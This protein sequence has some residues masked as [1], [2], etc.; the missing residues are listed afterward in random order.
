MFFQSKEKTPTEG[1]CL[2]ESIKKG[3][4]LCDWVR[5]GRWRIAW[6]GEE[7][8]KTQLFLCSYAHVLNRLR[9]LDKCDI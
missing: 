9:V 7:R 3:S 6:G 8:A 5:I 4:V 1:D 2:S